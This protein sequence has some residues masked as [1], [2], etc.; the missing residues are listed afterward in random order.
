V[1]I[2]SL[3]LALIACGLAPQRQI[4][5]VV[6]QDAGRPGVPVD[7]VDPAGLVTSISVATVDEP[8]DAS[9]V[10]IAVV[11]GRSDAAVIRWVGGACDERTTITFALREPTIDVSLNTTRKMTSFS[12]PDVGYS[13]KVAIEFTGPLGN[14]GFAWHMDPGS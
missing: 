4:R 6:P 1:F 12:C 11:P 10:G 3:A 8:G 5:T 7:V 9:K 14:R 2:A 13:R